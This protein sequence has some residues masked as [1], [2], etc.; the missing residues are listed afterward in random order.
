MMNNKT[1]P[2]DTACK[3]IMVKQITR[4]NYRLKLPIRTWSIKEPDGS[5]SAFV[6]ELEILSKGKTADEALYNAFTEML[7]LYEIITQVPMSYVFH[8]EILFYRYFL[9]NHIIKV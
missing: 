7:L 2:A 1:N 6:H 9:E 3:M 5:F 4:D 8:E